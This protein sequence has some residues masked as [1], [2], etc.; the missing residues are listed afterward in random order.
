MVAFKALY[1]VAQHPL[2]SPHQ[3]AGRAGCGSSC[4]E[5][6]VGPT[7][8]R[9]DTVTGSAELSRA[10]RKLQA[11]HSDLEPEELLQASK[12]G[13]LLHLLRSSGP[14]VVSSSFPKVLDI[15]GH[16]LAHVGITTARL[17]SKS[18][19]DDCMNVSSAFAAGKAH[20]VLV[21]QQVALKYPMLDLSRAE[22]CVLYDSG[23]SRTVCCICSFL[24]CASC[25]YCIEL[26]LECARM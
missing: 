23:L 9:G 19:L 25:H 17:D 20:V 10:S 6:D 24:L 14:A 2:L 3:P 13:S 22:L 12:C 16:L 15:C 5:V 1:Q 8:E 26:V 7:E 21:Q 18:R 4:S 11:L